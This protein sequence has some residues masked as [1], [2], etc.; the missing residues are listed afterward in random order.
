MADDVVGKLI[1]KVETDTDEAK[2]GLDG[3][4]DELKDTQREAKD[5]EKEVGKASDGISIKAVAIATAVGTAVVKMSKD[6]AKATST[7]QSGQKTIANATGATGKALEGLMQSAQNV[8]A[9]SDDSFEDVSSALGEI[10]TR[11]GLTG[12]A[13]ESATKDFLDFADATGQDVQQSVVSVTQAMN[14]WGIETDK[15]PALLD[16]LTYAGQASGVSVATLTANLTANAGTLQAMGY[17]LDEAISMMMQFETQGI[18]ANSVIMGMKKSFEDS[19]KAGTD[20][21]TR[22]RRTE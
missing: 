15:M 5:T 21:R 20:A 13:L 19:A 9:S 4:Q 7:I 18:D 16:K 1:F 6:I 17:S 8:F 12:S 11:L 10:N 2:K 22:P 14:R 3:F